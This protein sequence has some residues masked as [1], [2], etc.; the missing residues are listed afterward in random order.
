MHVYVHTL[1]A[2]VHMC[3]CISSLPISP[4]EHMGCTGGT[5]CVYAYVHMHLISLYLPSFL[6]LDDQNYQ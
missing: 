5:A 6:C 4:L 3:I 1:L 2:R